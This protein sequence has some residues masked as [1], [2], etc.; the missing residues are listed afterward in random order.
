MELLLTLENGDRAVED[1]QRRLRDGSLSIG[2]GADSDWVLPD[3]ARQL[4]KRHCVVERRGGAWFLTDTSANGG[5]IADSPEPIGRDGSVRLQDGLRLKLGDYVLAV[6]LPAD[7]RPSAA[8]FIPAAGSPF[9]QT[10]CR[11]KSFDL[12]RP[13]VASATPL[14]RSDHT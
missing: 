12:A 8:A 4:S 3:P 5:F 1:R 7:D 2:R 6:S 10:W 9:D 11:S 14:T 13:P